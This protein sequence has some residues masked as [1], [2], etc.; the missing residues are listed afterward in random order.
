MTTD[1]NSKIE[2]LKTTF[3]ATVGTLFADRSMDFND[4]Q[5]RID[6]ARANLNAKIAALTGA[7]KRNEAAITRLLTEGHGW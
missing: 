5:D 6:A 1:T 7:P 2:D 4:R 3:S